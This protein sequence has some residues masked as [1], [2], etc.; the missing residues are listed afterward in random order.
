VRSRHGVAAVLTAAAGTR[1]G[2]G[3]EQPLAQPEGQSLL[4]D[5]ERSMQEEGARKN[6]TPY[7]VVEPGAEGAV[8]VD[9]EKGHQ[10]KLFKTSPSAKARGA[11]FTD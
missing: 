9:W 6:I 11:D 7:R 10:E 5:A 2:A 8:T 4:A 3:A 1:L